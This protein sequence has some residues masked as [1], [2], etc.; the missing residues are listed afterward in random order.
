[1]PLLLWSTT[2][3]WHKGWAHSDAWAAVTRDVATP[4]PWQ[5]TVNIDE[6]RVHDPWRTPRARNEQPPYSW[7]T[8]KK[9]HREVCL[10]TPET[11]GPLSAGGFEPHPP[12]VEKTAH[13][14]PELRCRGGAAPSASSSGAFPQFAPVPCQLL[15]R[16][17]CADLFEDCSIDGTNI[18]NDGLTDGG[19]WD[20]ASVRRCHVTVNGD[21]IASFSL[22]AEGR[23]G[24]RS[25][26]PNLTASD[27][28]SGHTLEYLVLE[29]RS[30]TL[31]SKRH[32]K[33]YCWAM[34]HY[35][36]AGIS[37][38]FH[39]RGSMCVVALHSSRSIR[40]NLILKSSQLGCQ[41]TRHT[42]SRVSRLSL[43]CHDAVAKTRS[44]TL[45]FTCSPNCNGTGRR[46][47]GCR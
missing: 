17:C 2:L 34:A 10:S 32:R 46:R 36:S 4:A 43:H 35:G 37:R 27:L 21:E 6:L 1:M 25:R 24:L 40:L 13:L 45:N 22:P 29:S 42:V 28:L 31:V 15:L 20:Q 41:L 8:Q 47:H 39:V 12:L 23:S 9:G 7:H 14:L 18:I 26:L 5:S 30:Q 33:S 16:Q 38:W 44:I 11:S 19:I 3:T